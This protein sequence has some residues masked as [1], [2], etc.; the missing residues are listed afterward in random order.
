LGYNRFPSGQPFNQVDSKVKERIVGAVVLVALGV[1]LIPWVLDGRDAADTGSAADATLTLP[2]PD[3]RA[4]VRT[5]TVELEPE[6]RASAALGAT[7]EPT[8][9]AGS[10]AVTV[11]AEAKA[12]VSAQ[13]SAQAKSPATSPAPRPEAATIAAAPKPSTKAPEPDGWSV[14]V[15]AFSDPANARQLASRVSEFGYKARVSEFVSDG[16][17]MHRVRVEGYGTREEAEATASSL[18]AHGFQP[19]VLPPE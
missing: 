14:Q 10:A 1:W 15:G 9:A 7:P 4:P 2:T 11:S 6:P 5:E 16:A 13:A 17:P 3:V 19:R 8:P 18:R 12:Q